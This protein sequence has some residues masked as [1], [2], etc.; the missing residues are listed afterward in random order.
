MISREDIISYCLSVLG[1]INPMIDG[2]SD[3]NNALPVEDLISRFVETGLNESIGILPDKYLSYSEIL[4]DIV[5]LQDGSGYI[6][7][8]NDFTERVCFK[9]RGWRRAVRRAIWEDSPLYAQQKSKATRG[10]INRPVCAIVRNGNGYVLEYYSLPAE[11]RNP[12]VE[13]KM[14][15]PRVKQ[16]GDIA[17]FDMD[18]GILPVV[19]YL[20]CKHVCEATGELEMSGYFANEVMKQIELLP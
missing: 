18:K 13:V 16:S 5:S 10:G 8:P 9:M 7:L 14:Y 12:V 19:G 1:E 17:D 6:S 3:T 4:G 15:V 20:I 11:E 2:G